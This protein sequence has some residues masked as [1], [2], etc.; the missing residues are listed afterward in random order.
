MTEQNKT[1]AVMSQRHED[2]DSLDYFPTPPWATR[3]L[4]EHI[5][6]PNFIYPQQPD[7]DFVKYTCLEPACGAG[8]MAKVLEEYFPEVMSCDIADYGQDRIAD[9]LS[10]DVNEEYDFIITNPPFNLAEEFVLK[11]LPLAKESTAIFARTQFIE[12]VGRYE[13][14]FKQNPPTIIAQFTERVP[15]LKG[16]L[17]ATA[18]TATSYAWFIW[19]SDQTLFK[20][21]FPKFKTEVQWIPPTRTKLER[22]ADYEESMA[23][24][25]PRPTRHASQGN[26]FD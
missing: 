5:L 15:I 12:S 6:K 1:H 23:T 14:L 17:S 24:P 10:K 11:A 2:L 18:S 20:N 26:L 22:E 16:R 3:A 13:R 7:D 25:H 21:P 9:F 8:H 19:E 4:F